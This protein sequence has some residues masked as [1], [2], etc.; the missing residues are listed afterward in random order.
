MPN[1]HYFLEKSCKNR[2]SVP[3]SPLAS[4]Q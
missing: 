1:T 3:K 2:C 4:G